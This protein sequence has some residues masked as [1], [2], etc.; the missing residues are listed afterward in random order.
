MRIYTCSRNWDAMLTCIY[1]AWTSR[2]GQQ[3]IRLELEPVEQYT[4]FNEYIHVD[5]NK[6]KAD[7]V[8]DAIVEKISSYVYYELTFCSMA[9]EKDVLDNI[10]R[11]L[12]LGFAYG[13]KVLEMVQF[14][15]VMRNNEIRRRL[16]REVSR[17]T[18]A[19][20]FQRIND[21]FY[22]AHI[23]P[24]SNLVLALGR[25]FQDRMPSE[26]W[27]IVDDVHLEALIHPANEDFYLRF[28][29]EIELEALKRTEKTRDEYT[30]L[31]KVFFDTIAI[32]ERIN[33]KLQKNLFPLWARKH[34]VEFTE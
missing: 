26:N 8:A 7:S 15:D 10:Y 23:E 32:K 29:S 6:G 27:M 20:R 24:K 9:C 3:N 1:E 13:P 33:P 12:I 30:D 5:V 19:V 16:G 21:S 14:K 22:V 18:E 31:W 17:F 4:L 25:H 2:L 34:A 11:V 28:L